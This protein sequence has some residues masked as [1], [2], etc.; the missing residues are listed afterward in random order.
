[1]VYKKASG[2]VS[3]Q[4]HDEEC[5]RGVDC[6]DLRHSAGNVS[7]PG[8][9]EA[10]HMRIL[11][12]LHG[13]TLMHRAALGHPRQERVAQVRQRDPSVADYA[14]YVP[15]GEAVAK[16]A[17]WQGQGA[18]IRYLSSHRR[19]EHVAMD[20][21]VLE[22]FGFPAGEVLFRQAAE[23][24]ADVARRALPDVLIED[25]A[26][27]IGGEVEMAYPHLRPDEQARVT[28]IVV[29]EFEGID[30]LPDLLLELRGVRE[31]D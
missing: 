19:P 21:A 4:A 17:R 23:S 5:E 8:R 13:T 2:L 29:R 30:H 27:S 7:N 22:Q 15:V 16:L 25:D 6:S 11:V 26:E 18:Q 1:M 12:F 9:E 28:G 20:I 3:C 14:A 31:Q 10:P 24:Y